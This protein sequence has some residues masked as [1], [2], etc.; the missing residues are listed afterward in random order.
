ME[1]SFIIETSLGIIEIP[2]EAIN[3]DLEPFF[4][5]EWYNKLSKLYTLNSLSIENDWLKIHL[6]DEFYGY[7]E[8]KIMSVT[9]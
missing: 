3:T 9:N 1:S 5:S 6:D 7:P 2:S 4:E 8:Y